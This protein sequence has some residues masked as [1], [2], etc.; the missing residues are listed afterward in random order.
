MTKMTMHVTNLG[1]LVL[2]GVPTP[3]WADDEDV[4][5]VALVVGDIDGTE[6][7]E[8][9]VALVVGDIGGTEGNEHFLVLGG[10]PTPSWADEA[11]A[12]EASKSKSQVWWS[13]RPWKKSKP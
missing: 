8:V 3:S 4:D 2:G 1:F 11:A 5:V 9:V 12:E 13:G 7:N 10:V 6:G